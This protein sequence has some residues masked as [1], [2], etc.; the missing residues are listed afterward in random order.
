M[1]NSICTCGWDIL[2]NKRDRDPNCPEH[3]AAAIP[4]RYN[5]NL[6]AYIADTEEARKSDPALDAKKPPIPGD[7]CW[8]CDQPGTDHKHGTGRSCGP[9]CGMHGSLCHSEPDA[10]KWIEDCL[11]AKNKRIAE[12][13]EVN[14][15]NDE[16]KP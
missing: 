13:T 6:A 15:P 2:G 14:P 3:C 1:S 12:L 16:R 5:G 9:C 7:H 8:Y 4:E 10:Y 11:R